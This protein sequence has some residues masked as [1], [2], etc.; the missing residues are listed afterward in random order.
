MG[1]MK[2][3]GNKIDIKEP[4]K[5]NGEYESSTPVSAK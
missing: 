3:N 4:F 1:N 2:E 5:D